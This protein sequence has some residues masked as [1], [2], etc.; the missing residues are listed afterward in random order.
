MKECI[1]RLV[2]IGFTRNPKHI[3]DEIE[4]VSATMLREGWRLYDTCMED[5]LGC[6]HLFFEREIAAES[7]GIQVEPPTGHHGER[8]GAPRELP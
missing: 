2:R 1:E 8:E 7:V 3:F 6:A 4:S 5:G